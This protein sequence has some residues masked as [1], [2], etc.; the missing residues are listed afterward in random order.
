MLVPGKIDPDSYKLLVGETFTFW[1]SFPFIYEWTHDSKPLPKNTE[2]QMDGKILVIIKATIENSG[3]YECLGLEENKKSR[4]RTKLT[5]HP[6]KLTGHHHQ[7]I[8]LTMLTINAACV[9]H[10]YKS[11]NDVK[12]F[13]LS[14]YQWQ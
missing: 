1:C 8:Y 3:Y 6:G 12:M 13:Q 5:V 9:L 2:L 11:L 10:V 4:A 7:L 14:K